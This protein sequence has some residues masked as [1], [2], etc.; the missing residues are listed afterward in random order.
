MT[1]SR[2]T[3]GSQALKFRLSSCCVL[4]VYTSDVNPKICTQGEAEGSDSSDIAVLGVESEN[5]GTSY[6]LLLVSL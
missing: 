1:K 6:C 2:V 5:G 3:G 4:S